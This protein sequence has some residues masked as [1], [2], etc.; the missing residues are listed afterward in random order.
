MFPT[1]KGIACLLVIKMNGII[2]EDKHYVTLS[3][4]Q[5]SKSSGANELK[6]EA[7]SDPS[8]AVLSL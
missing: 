7:V 3:L 1:E 4:T 8:K 2:L 6:Q 5:L